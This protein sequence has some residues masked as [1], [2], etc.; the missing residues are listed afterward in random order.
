MTGHR[1]IKF[2][3]QDWQRDPALRSCGPAARGIWM[4]MICVMHDGEPYGHL[5]INGKPATLRQI[6]RFCGETEKDA[7]R[8]VA[9]LEESGV[10]SRADDG[11]IY[12]RRMVKDKAISDRGAIDGKTG[13]N[14]ALKPTKLKVVKG[15]GN[16]GGLTGGDNPSRYGSGYRGAQTLEAEAESEARVPPIA[17]HPQVKAAAGAADISFAEFWQVYPRKVGKDAARKSW[18]N[19]VK[20]ATIPDIMAAL[21][22]QVWPVDRQFIPHPSTWLNQGRW[23]DD[24]LA[25]APAPTDAAGIMRQDWNLPLMTFPVAPDDPDPQPELLH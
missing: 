6:A 8:L 24:P 21:A 16:G 23:Q 11:T 4:D 3:P 19:A 13:G 20:R 12:S 18:G 25:A 5:T 1:W 2:W 10:F 7:T 15:G 14:P 17:P 22:R 9:E